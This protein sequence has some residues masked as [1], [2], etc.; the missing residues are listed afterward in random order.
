MWSLP[1]PNI[2]ARALYLTCVS[3]TLPKVK[4]AKLEALEDTVADAA[5]RYEAAA[6]AAAL[7]TL[8]DLKGE[9]ADKA[10]Q[11]ELKKNYTQRMARPYAPGR[12]VYNEIKASVRF[13]RCP[14]CGERHVETVDHQL[15]KGDYPLLAVVPVNLVPA[16]RSC[17]ALKG[18]AAPASAEE[19]T[20]HP[21]YDDI[22][23]QQ[24]LFARV[25]E[26][27]PAAVEFFVKPPEEWDKVLVAR[28]RR[29]F[30]MFKL[31]DLYGPHA[32]AEMSSLRHYLKGMDTQA[33]AAHLG[34]MAD[35]LFVDDLNH[36]RGVM[37]QALA[38]NSWYVNG[39]F[40]AV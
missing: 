16:C 6:S 39:G 20:L 8:K 7:H 15:P 22:G 17:N 3:N 9:P 26:D 38:A 2:P 13:G 19:Q 10:V 14:L 37:Y 30:R 4:R 23:K 28:V 24:W 27:A 36:W 31:G 33:V 35:S 29:H 21:Y 5:D 40:A 32:A 12:D 34:K 18:E 1:A 11:E 25:L